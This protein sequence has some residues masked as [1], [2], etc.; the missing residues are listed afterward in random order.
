MAARDAAAKGPALTDEVILAD[1]FVEVARAHSRC[2][3]LPLRRRLE[4][5]FGASAGDPPG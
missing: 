5:C 1:E 2:E 3:W 4:E